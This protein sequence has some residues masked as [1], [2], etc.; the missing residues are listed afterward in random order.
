M[1]V[2]T[3]RGTE[4]QVAV[5]FV[6]FDITAIAITITTITKHSMHSHS[7]RLV[8][9][10]V[11]LWFLASFS[12]NLLFSPDSRGAIPSN[13]NHLSRPAT[14]PQT[15]LNHKFYSRFI[16]IFTFFFALGL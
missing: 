13:P 11:V 15:K 12:R 5:A 1:L 14:Q 8:V 16:I 2:P 7:C 4:G 9:V 6:E 3:L 10:V